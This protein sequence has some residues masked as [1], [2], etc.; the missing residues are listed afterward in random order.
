LFQQILNINIYTYFLFNSKQILIVGVKTMKNKQQL[1]NHLFEIIDIYKNDGNIRNNMRELYMQ[2]N[3]PVRTVWLIFKREKDLASLSEIELGIWC[4]GLYNSTKDSLINEKKYFTTGE[5]LKIKEYIYKE[6][7]EIKTNEIILHNTVKKIILGR[8][9]YCCPFISVYDLYSFY[10][11]SLITYN[12]KIKRNPQLIGKVSEQLQMNELYPITITL[13][14][15][16]LNLN[17]EGFVYSEENKN[18]KIKF[19]FIN[20]IFISEI[21][22]Y[23]GITGIAKGVAISNMNNRQLEGGVMLLIVNYSKKELLD[24]IIDDEKTITFDKNDRID[25]LHTCI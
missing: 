16:N 14:V 22:Q 10:T 2:K 23:Y 25:I 9:Y 1:I 21:N 11:N 4:T 18:L 3:M 24:I 8:T 13:N 15:V 6:K 7:Q 12:Y 5:I 19:P 20:D 17:M